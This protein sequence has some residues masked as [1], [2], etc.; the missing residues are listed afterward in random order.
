MKTL[1]R[2]SRVEKTQRFMDLVSG[3]CNLKVAEIADQVA[4]RAYP[5]NCNS[6]QQSLRT[7]CQL[8]EPQALII[9]VIF[10]C[11]IHIMF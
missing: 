7:V 1:G 3:F 4:D 9:I 10:R 6:P 11:W 8:E 5:T 2:K